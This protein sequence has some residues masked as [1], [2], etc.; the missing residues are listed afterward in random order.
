MKIQSS[1]DNQY[2]KSRQ[3]QESDQ[4]SDDVS[5][6]GSEISSDSSEVVPKN[7]PDRIETLEK[8]LQSLKKEK[9]SSIDL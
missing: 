9:E 1:N 3:K 6:D 2:I 8:K 5:D 4:D 7:R